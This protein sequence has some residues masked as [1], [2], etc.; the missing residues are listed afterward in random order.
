MV[1]SP[2]P[3]IVLRRLLIPSLLLS[4]A[5]PVGGSDALPGSKL[6]T[7]GMEARSKECLDQAWTNSAHIPRVSGGT[8]VPGGGEEQ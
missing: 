3:G 8:G 7:P 6:G 4:F 1:P 5:S 2:D